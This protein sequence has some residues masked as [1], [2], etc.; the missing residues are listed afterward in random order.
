MNEFDVD[1]LVVFSVVEAPLQ[2]G[3]VLQYRGSGLISSWIRWLTHGVHSHSAMLRI[4]EHGG[5]VLEV[6]E[7]KGGRAVP[8]LG[9]VARNG[10]RIDVFRP[11]VDVFA[12]DA[13]AAV[14]RMRD[15]TSRHYGYLGI[16]RIFL[17]RMPFV[18]RFMRAS[19]ADYE[20]GAES[21]APFCSHAVAM[22][23][24]AGGVDP[25]P[26]KP[27]A[28]VTPADLTCSLLFD[29]VCTLET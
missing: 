10:G 22:A 29:Y 11:R 14:E 25:V 19:T 15:L 21:C 13:N 24:S 4:D 18:W 6:R 1:N 12:Y 9:E 26:R 23:C 8:L 5:D 27:D 2:N 3:D 17:Q 28:L 16:L 7:F 20:R